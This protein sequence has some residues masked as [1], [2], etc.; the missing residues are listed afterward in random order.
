MAPGQNIDE[1]AAAGGCAGVCWSQRE[2]EP[3]S[4]QSCHGGGVGRPSSTRYGSSP[5]V[6]LF[7]HNFEAEAFDHRYHP[8]HVNALSVG[9]SIGD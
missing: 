3:A 4:F 6:A 9:T 8:W 7:S 2:R 1:V 5:T